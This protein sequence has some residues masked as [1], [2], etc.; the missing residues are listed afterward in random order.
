M[1]DDTDWVKQHIY[2][3]VHR[4]FNSFIAETGKP[5]SV[6]SIGMNYELIIH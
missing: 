2:K 6:K 4:G 1:S 5:D 3:R